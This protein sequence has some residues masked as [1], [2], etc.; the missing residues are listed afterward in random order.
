M[1]QFISKIKFSDGSS[2]TVGTDRN[3]GEVAKEATPFTICTIGYDDDGNLQVLNFN[4]QPIA[5]VM[6]NVPVVIEYDFS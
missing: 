5:C 6:N 1:T 3:T 4:G 2:Y